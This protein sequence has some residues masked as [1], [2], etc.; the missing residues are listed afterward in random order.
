[1][2]E[3]RCPECKRVFVRRSPVRGKFQRLLTAL[4]FYP[5]HCEFCEHRFTAYAKAFKAGEEEE[6][7]RDYERIPVRVPATLSWEGGEAA[8]TVT[9]VSPAG[10][11]VESSAQVPKETLIGLRLHIA[12]RV[13]PITVEAAVLRRAAQG[14]LGF[15]FLK[16]QE[17]ER[18]RLRDFVLGVRR[19]LMASQPA[20]RPSQAVP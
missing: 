5:Y 3:L 19:T 8:G 17:M 15:Q 6:D 18:G 9:D 1:M 12:E 16:M 7:V 11:S 10:C 20:S 4:G 14:I 13:P 2:A